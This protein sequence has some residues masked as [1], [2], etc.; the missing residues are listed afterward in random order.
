MDQ[1]STPCQRYFFTSLLELR[2]SSW[3]SVASSC[4]FLKYLPPKNPTIP[5][6]KATAAPAFNPT[7]KP[8]GPPHTPPTA[9]PIRG[10]ATA[11]S[12][13]AWKA[14]NNKIIIIKIKT[15]T[16]VNTELNVWDLNRKNSMVMI[17]LE[18]FRVCLDPGLPPWLEPSACGAIDLVPA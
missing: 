6:P 8:T 12:L 14:K 17:K 15:L 3:I 4:F 11:L 2:F 5:P 1:I 18:N 13:V 7:A 16:G 10:K 9:A